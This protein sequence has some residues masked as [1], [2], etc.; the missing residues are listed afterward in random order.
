MA[1]GS[2]GEPVFAD[3]T[4]RKLFLDTLGEACTR[5]AWRIPTCVLMGNHCHLPVQTPEP[6]LVADTTSLAMARSSSLFL[7]GFP[8]V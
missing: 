1:R 7:L 3:D 4:D 2:H 6:S 8:L 5:T